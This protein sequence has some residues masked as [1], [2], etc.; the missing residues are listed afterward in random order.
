VRTKLW[1]G[2]I[3][4]AAAVVVTASALGGPST[5]KHCS[6]CDQACDVGILRIGDHLLRPR[7]DHEVHILHRNSPEENLGSEDHGSAETSAVADRFGERP[8]VRLNSP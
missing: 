7:M 4:G 1:L 6:H 5:S 3:V 8:H 2:V